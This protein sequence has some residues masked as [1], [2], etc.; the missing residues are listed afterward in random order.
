MVFI[1]IGEYFDIDRSRYMSKDLF[2][3]L[4]QGEMKYVDRL[5]THI[6]LGDYTYIFS[7]EDPRIIT[8]YLKSILKYMEEP[9]C[10]FVLYS[11]FK[12]ICEALDA[13]PRQEN[14]LVENIKEVLEEMD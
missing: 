9:L 6:A 14:K 11:K 1:K 8:Y 13:D 4:K 12:I 7:V 10:T 3:K 5:E 2:V